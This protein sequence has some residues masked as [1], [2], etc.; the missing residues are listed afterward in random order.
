LKNQ[1]LAQRFRGLFAQIFPGAARPVQL[2]FSGCPEI[3]LPVQF[4]YGGQ[5]GGASGIFFS[6]IFKKKLAKPF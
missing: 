3:G 1:G 2:L 6:E 4:L 5:K